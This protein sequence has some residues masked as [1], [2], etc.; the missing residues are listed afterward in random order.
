MG[1]RLAT[2][3]RAELAKR[4]WTQRDLST[5]A[6]N[7]SESTLSDILSRGTGRIS[8]LNKIARALGVPLGDILEAAGFPADTV[9]EQTVEDR[10]N[11]LIH[12]APWLAEGLDKLAEMSP[13]LQRQVVAYI[14]FHYQHDQKP[15]K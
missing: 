13:E 1:S 4:G 12:A 6:D 8:N 5:R 7:L 11:F 14:E 2:Y 3:I 15:R 10:L 9:S